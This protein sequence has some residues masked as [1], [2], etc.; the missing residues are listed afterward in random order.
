MKTKKIISKRTIVVLTITVIATMILTGCNWFTDSGKSNSGSGDNPERCVSVAVVTGVR[1]N[2]N[3]ISVNSKVISDRVYDSAYSCGRVLLV[4]CDG[5]PEIYY[6]TDIE[7]PD[8]KGLSESKLRSIAEGHRDE[9]L[10]AFDSMGTA[11]APEADTLEAIRLA[12]NALREDKK[13]EE[14]YLVIVDSGLS[15]TGYLDFTEGILNADTEEIVAELKSGKAIPDF[16][17]TDIVWMYCGDTAEPQKSLSEAQ[18]AKLREIYAAIF[19]AG[20]ADSY[21]FRDEAPT[22]EPYTGLPYVTE[23]EAEGRSIEV[24]TM[25]S[26]RLDPGK[27]RFVGD[28][29]EFIDEKV[30]RE[31]IKKAADQLLK[32]PD[33][34]AY[35][36]GGTAGADGDSDYCKNLSEARARAVVNVLE[37]YGIPAGRLI[38]AG[39]GGRTP[40]HVDDTDSD[41]KMIESI[42]QG[43][44]SV[45]IVDINDE[46]YG[47]KIR[48][49]IDRS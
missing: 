4:R 40:W 43:N 11:K 9:I 26:V 18:K 34:I 37:G 38:P 22:S 25:S 7:E 48:E 19:E 10:S 1:S 44:R 5:E 20:N 32:Y 45:W 30:A 21:T 47:G 28:S 8:V 29:D 46:E 39:L 15:T 14:K 17:G 35:V 16:A 27:V 33:S 13:G 41:G 3:R 12:A 36:V 49:T 24:E 31:E 6:M 42:A 2:N 23:V